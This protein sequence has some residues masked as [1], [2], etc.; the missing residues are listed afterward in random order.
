M[1]PDCCCVSCCCCRIW[2]TRGALPLSAVSSVT[3]CG[4]EVDK[5]KQEGWVGLGAGAGRRGAVRQRVGHPS[6]GPR[7]G[8]EER[9]QGPLTC[10]STL[11]QPAANPGTLLQ[12][13]LTANNFW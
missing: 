12:L 4:R 9:M 10:P 8:H 7:G 2:E 13:G 1:S 6:A 11:Q 5:R 3:F